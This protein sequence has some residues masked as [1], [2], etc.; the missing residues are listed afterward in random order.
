MSILICLLSGPSSWLNQQLPWLFA[1]GAGGRAVAILQDTLLEIRTVRDSY[2]AP[3]GKSFVAKD[4]WPQ[5]RK[6]QWSPDGTLLACA[7]S[8][9]SVGVY[10]LLASPLFEIPSPRGPA[11][12]LGD[13]NQ[14]PPNALAEMVFIDTR[15]KIAHWSYELLCF[16]YYGQLHA[17]FVSPTQGF[18]PSHVFSFSS[19]LPS[20]IT[21]V[22]ADYLRHLLIV[23]TPIS[24]SGSNSS[25]DVRGTTGTVY[26]L[27]VWRIL[28]DNPF[29][30][31]LPLAGS[32]KSP[33]QRRWLSLQPFAKAS[34]DN[35]IVKITPSPDGSSLAAIHLSGAVSIWALPSLKCQSFWPLDSQPG[36]D[37]LSP[38]L[39]QL[40]AQRR[41]RSPFLQNPF[42][43]H[44]VDVNW[45]SPTCVILAR[46]SG[47]VTV[48]GISDLCNKLG[49]SAEFFDGSPRIGPAFDGT[50]L[51]IEC[52]QKV[53]RKRLQTT[54]EEDAAAVFT[55]TTDKRENARIVEESSDE[56]SDKQVVIQRMTR[57]LLYWVTDSERFQPPRKRPKFTTRTYRL[58]GFK[59]TTPD[60]LYLWKLEA[61]E[62]GEALALARAYGL[63]C[64]LVYQRQW[65]NTTATIAAIHD[66]LSKVSKRNW[67]LR[68]CI[69]R[70]PDDVDAA[71][72]LLLYGLKNTDLQIA[73]ETSSATGS[74]NDETKWSSLHSDEIET[75]EADLSR[76]EKERQRQ[77]LAQ[78]DFQNLTVE[79]KMLISTRRRL[80]Q[81]FDR[82]Q[83]YEIILGGPHLAAERF[84]AK[85]FEHFRSQ[86]SF[87]AATEFA[88]QG[89]WQAVAT[90]FTFNGDQ[91]LP[92]RL[93]ICS[94]FPETLA[95]FEYRS[96]LP[97]CDVNGQVFLW[98]QQCLRDPA[99]W[100]ECQ[101]AR[102]AI[103]LEQVMELEAQDQF[104]GEEMNRTWKP[105][106]TAGA[107][108]SAELV[109]QWY[110]LRA[111]D[112]DRQSQ[113]VEN[114]IDLIKLGL[115]RNVPH[116]ENINHQLLTLETLV[117]DMHNERTTLEKLNSMGQ[118]DVVQLLMSDC[119]HD[120]FLPTFHRWLSPYLRRVDALQ[121]GRRSQ[122]LRDFLLTKSLEKLDWT[123]QVVANSTVDQLPSVPI[124]NDTSELISL[125][126]DCIYSCQ[127]SDQLEVAMKIY[128]CLPERPAAAAAS[129][130]L[131]QLHD[132]LDIL[133]T[134]LEAADTLEDHGVSLTPALI[135]A[136]Q[137]DVEQVEQLFIRLTRTVV[138]KTHQFTEHQ[139]KE[140]LQDMLRLQETVFTCI[141]PQLC[142]EI[143][144]GSLLSCAKKECISW[145]GHLLQVDPTQQRRPHHEAEKGFEM[146]AIPFQR[147]K[148]LVLQ[149]AQEYFNSSENLSDPSLELASYC[150]SLITA[151]DEEIQEE[152]DLI[153][154]VHLMAD[155]GLDMPPLKI[156]LSQN[157]L[158]LID[159]VLKH[160]GKAYKNTS[161]LVRLG[162]LLRA[163]G[164]KNEDLDGQIYVRIA[165]TALVRRDLDVACQMCEKLRLANQAIGW[166]VCSRLAA[167]DELVDLDLRRGLASFALVYCPED[168]MEE[169]LQLSW[170]L[171]RRQLAETSTRQIEMLMTYQGG[172]ESFLALMDVQ[173][174]DS[175]RK[176][177]ARTS[178]KPSSVAP[179]SYHQQQQQHLLQ[180]TAETTRQLVDAVRNTL[181]F[182]GDDR[183]KKE[184]KKTAESVTSNE[185]CNCLG[186]PVFYWNL[187]SGVV[188]LHESR[189]LAT[190][191]RSF[192]A[193]P[194]RSNNRLQLL[195]SSRRMQILDSLQHPY[196]FVL[197][198]GAGCR[199]DDVQLLVQLAESIFPDDAFL[200][201]GLWLDLGRPEKSWPAWTRLP[202]TEITLQ[203]AAYYFAVQ[204]NHYG[205]CYF[206]CYRISSAKDMRADTRR[207]QFCFYNRVLVCCLSLACN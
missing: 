47:A 43:F 29:Y 190:G 83:I 136:K 2:A 103:D 22:C 93:A 39:L 90:M 20:G 79:Q 78:I 200:A 44:P 113:L 48:C 51:G 64:D 130:E 162:Q 27:T 112:I 189:F 37:E 57:S 184:A 53:Q 169:L 69:E 84:D 194:V 188:P 75:T 55:A 118:S 160:G 38:S 176:N 119:T 180:T 24:S 49:A 104:Y 5:W 108:L 110:C 170:A 33:L 171:E 19:Q 114:A 132:Q 178:R 134:L 92:H 197:T 129:R 35:T 86:S 26:G 62:Y 8:S 203:L 155:Y 157:R 106:R 60:E 116:L 187:W 111:A 140:I 149:A 139:W 46:C 175:Y 154:A 95:P 131:N 67:V 138:R 147:S 206:Y 193:Q 31:L 124:V 164:A 3:I 99:D 58:L 133:Q 70:V 16:D 13:K 144:V 66:Y 145:A 11:G 56:E 45:W 15:T 17:Y 41:I 80:L 9:G 23:A 202:S 159:Q 105:F 76:R 185:E 101:E 72:E 156:R 28:D 85:F 192:S 10:D 163:G 146:S 12:S 121:P 165:E 82:L 150:L 183:A 173:C 89:D 77:L 36:Y 61:E 198:D 152:R 117:Y 34:Y 127:R 153:S 102:R 30:S 137:N 205:P 63:D 97:E 21:S 98:Q 94:C 32:E 87:E 40:P 135:A 50:F 168:K 91:T 186:L 68:E 182:T 115:E 158:V 100:C 143:L 65:R 141:S 1:V 126:V 54:A 122:L 6:L 125:A 123:L 14:H 204:V 179:E 52:E 191:Y 161:R 107:E 151:Q 199:V 4:P 74:V 71:R 7:Q 142:R 18:T 120:N 195:S 196:N 172:D 148:Q 207:I 181:K 109:S 96:L 177:V 42:R 167:D 174:V 128:D 81:F 73:V 166:T 25:D 88:R 59:R 201:L